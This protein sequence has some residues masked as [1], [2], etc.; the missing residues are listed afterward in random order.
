MTVSLDFADP[1]SVSSSEVD[2]LEMTIWH[3]DLFV[4]ESTG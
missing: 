4:I 1:S 2:D 3:G